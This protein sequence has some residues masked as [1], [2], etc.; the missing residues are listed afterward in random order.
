MEKIPVATSGRGGFRTSRSRTGLDECW[1]SICGKVPIPLRGHH[2]PDRTYRG[3]DAAHSS[4]RAEQT[5]SHREER[6]Q[7][8]GGRLSEGFRILFASTAEV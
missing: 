3:I 2:C 7:A 1:C 5:Y 8:F 6:P 4:V